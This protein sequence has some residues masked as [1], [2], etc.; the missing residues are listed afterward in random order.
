MDSGGRGSAAAPKMGASLVA[1]WRC[2]AP[3]RW[4]SHN[5]S[6][7]DDGSSLNGRTGAAC[8]THTSSTPAREATHP[9]CDPHLR[10]VSKGGDAN[11]DQP[12][13]RVSQAI[14]HF[15]VVG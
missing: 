2:G 1:D 11:A 13:R 15:F 10:P 5:G 6:G 12:P 9:R 3:Y 4:G 14:L 8:D 7:L